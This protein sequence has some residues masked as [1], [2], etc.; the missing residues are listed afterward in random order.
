M[1]IISLTPMQER[2]LSECREEYRQIGLATG[3]VDVAAVTP[4]FEA[5]YREIGRP[6]VPVVRLP[7][8]RLALLAVSM[9][10]MIMTKPQDM[11]PTKDAMVALRG[12]L[13]GQLW[14]QLRDQ[15]WGQ[16]GGQLGDQLGGQLW[17][18]LRDQLWDQLGKCFWGQCDVHWVALYQF[19]REIGCRFKAVDVSRIALWEGAARHCGWWWPCENIVVASDRP[20]ETHWNTEYRLHNSAGPAVL[21]SD[22]YAL[23]ALNGVRVPD[24]LA[25]TPAEQL[26]PRKIVS[27]ENAEQRREGVRKVGVER[28]VQQM[29]A[30]TLDRQGDYELITLHLGDERIRPYLKMRNPSLGV[31][32]VEGVHPNCETVQEAL[33]WRNGSDLQP[34][35]IT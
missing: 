5:M 23:Y 3:P 32:H 17:G 19:S 9:L 31:F 4:V 7:S 18:Q 14:D 16:L 10:A 28:L 1:K 6:P 15:L 22:G 30:K 13:G 34:V 35:T 8:P 11:Q 27:I 2:R 26:D 20:T 25:T 12:Q 24:W 33:T 21:F 29:G